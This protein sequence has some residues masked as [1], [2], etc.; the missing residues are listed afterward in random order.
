V[1]G[2]SQLLQ[3]RV[4]PQVV[5]G[6]H[7]VVAIQKLQLR[8]KTDENEWKMLLPFSF[9]YLFYKNWSG[10][11]TAGSGNGSGINGNTKTGKYD[12]KI[13]GNER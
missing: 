1:A 5:A 2:A 8:M 10:R 13:D 3:L 9:P 12:R 11:E 6:G 7:V 4:Q